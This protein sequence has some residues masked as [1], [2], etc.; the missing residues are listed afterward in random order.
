MPLNIPGYR[1][2]TIVATTV[3]AFQTGGVIDG[4]PVTM[5]HCTDSMFTVRWR[6]L[7]GLIEAAT[8]GGDALGPDRV[9]V[10]VDRARI[11]SSTIDTAGL[12]IMNQCQQPMFFYAGKPPGNLSDVTIE[13]VRWSAAP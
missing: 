5:N 1:P 4:F 11:S 6:S 7:A 10:Q 12:M 13:Y 8:Y 9:S 3:R 2:G